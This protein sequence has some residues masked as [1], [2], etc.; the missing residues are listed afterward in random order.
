MLLVYWQ[1]A[2]SLLR[3]GGTFQGSTRELL[4]YLLMTIV[5][6]AMASGGALLALRRRKSLHLFLLALV[7]MMCGSIGGLIDPRPAAWA[8][9]AVLITYTLLL[10]RRS[11]LC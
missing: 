5:A 7:L 3:L 2:A 6:L 10:G 11:Y 4:Q 8:I 9:F 1:L